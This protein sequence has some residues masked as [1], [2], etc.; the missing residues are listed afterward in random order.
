MDSATRTW[1]TWRKIAVNSFVEARI[2]VNSNF[3]ITRIYF[4]DNDRGLIALATV[5][6]FRC[7]LFGTGPPSRKNAVPGHRQISL[8]STT[9]LD[10]LSLLK[11]L[12]V[13]R[14][15]TIK[16]SLDSSL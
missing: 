16:Y 1:T 13:C 12:F 9:R 7:A 15:K 5:A 10:F 11:K 6:Q 8:E 3:S 2:E 4:S 14:I